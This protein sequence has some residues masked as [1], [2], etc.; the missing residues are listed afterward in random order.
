MSEF[1]DYLH[2]VFERFGPIV[3]RRMFGGHMIYHQRLPI[4]LVIDETLYL[5]ADTENSDRFKALGLAQFGY[6]KQGKWIR[7]PYYQVP[8][9]LYED[10]D[11]AVEWAR[12]A[13]AA[14]LRA[15]QPDRTGTKPDTDDRQAIR[16]R[17]DR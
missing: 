14:A 16:D 4:G 8:E 7:L 12:Q 9:D 11:M 10:R 2:E 5:K 1:T 13:Y 6:E 3:T 17:P 15:N